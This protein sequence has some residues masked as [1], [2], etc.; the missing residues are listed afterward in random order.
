MA[1]LEDIKVINIEGTPI[2]VDDLSDQVK[3][4]VDVYNVFRND[5]VSA[6]YELIKVQGA[7]R[8]IQREIVIT[9]KKENEEAES[10]ETEDSTKE[11]ETTEEG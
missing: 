6:K 7:L 4:L 2:A 1:K 11:T 5:E 10:K 3:N 8:D 9:I